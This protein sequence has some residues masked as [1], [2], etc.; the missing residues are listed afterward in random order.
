MLPKLKLQTMEEEYK[1]KKWVWSEA[2]FE[3]MGWHDC[4]IRAVAFS[5]E[6]FELLFDIDYIFTWSLAKSNGDQSSV[7]ISPATLVFENV[8][9]AKFDVESWGSLEISDIRRGDGRKPR[10]AEHINRE[11]EWLWEIECQE[12]SIQ[13]RSVGYKQYI[14][15]KPQLSQNLIIDLVARGGYSF[16][17]GRTDLL[18]T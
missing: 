6:T 10:N 1:I 3:C 15:S 5:R 14:R 17:K 13:L 4:L 18:R 11:T 7:W 9:E 2:D 16:I 8:N 12:G